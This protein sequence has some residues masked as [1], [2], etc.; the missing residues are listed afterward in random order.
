MTRQLSALGLAVAIAIASTV[1]SASVAAQAKPATSARKA[2]LDRSKV[3]EPAKQPVL[4]VPEWTRTKLNNGAELIVSQKKGLPLVTVNISFIGGSYQFED[5]AKLGVAALTAQ[6]LSEG[7]STRSGDQLSEAMQMLGT[8]ITSSV[9]T[10]SGSLAFTALA[11]KLEPALDL[12]ADMLLN[13]SF[14]ADALARRKGQTLVSLTQQKDQ[15]PAIASKVFA[16]VNYGEA[17]PYGRR[18]NEATVQGIAR[19]DVADFHRSYYKPGRALV[20]VVGDVDPVRVRAAFEKSFANWPAGG[21]RPAFSYPAPPAPRPAAIYLVDK[22]KAAQSVVMIGGPGPTRNTPDYYALSVMNFILGGNFQS[23]LNYLIRE[24]KGYSYGAASTF[25][26]G[27]GPGP[28][29]ASSSVVTAKSDSSLIEFMNELRGAQGGR[30]FTD[31]EIKEAKQSLVQRLPD[32]F[33]SVNDISGAIAGIYLQD[34]PETYYQDYAARINAV[35][36]EDLVRVAKRYI[37]LN[38]VNI[39]IVGDRAVI[40]EPLRRTGIAPI[41]LT[42]IEG[43]PVP[44]A[45]P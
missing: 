24:V 11:D 13:P 22:P 17:H 19:D 38:T 14:P 9:G 45:T 43:R 16:K 42:D 41:V 30:P 34:L 23:R 28:F 39:V 4:R 3:P 27:K 26:Y 33:S 21:E 2:S 6:M 37:D 44:A 8:Q 29:S 20:T 1:G 5:P 18:S 25:A 7:T 10:E 12:M 35:T 15:P 31:A 36:P 32:R 40:E